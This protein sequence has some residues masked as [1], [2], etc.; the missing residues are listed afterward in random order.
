[1]M[2]ADD[3]EEGDDAERA[4]DDAE[5]Q[6]VGDADGP[7]ADKGQHA[8][9]ARDDDLA[10]KIADE[11]RVDFGEDRDDFVPQRGLAH[12]HEFMP[13]MGDALL[14]GEKII[15]VDRDKTEAEQEAERLPDRPERRV[16]QIGDVLLNRLL[17][18]GKIGFQP[19]LN[20]RVIVFRTACFRRGQREFQGLIGGGLGDGELVRRRGQDRRGG[21]DRSSSGLLSGGLVR[22]ASNFATP[23]LTMPGRDSKKPPAWSTR[24]GKRKAQKRRK[25]ITAR[26][27]TRRVAVARFRPRFCANATTGSSTR[28]MMTAS[29]MG[30]RIG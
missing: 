5:H 9:A 29:P 26:R 1:M 18:G 13:V 7:E 12:R 21:V 27:Q 16:N 3:A 6:A 25:P 14:V 2:L 23:L 30:S 10:A 20:G 8:V 17:N 28:A 11:R 15:D 24:G 19:R 4:G 22:L